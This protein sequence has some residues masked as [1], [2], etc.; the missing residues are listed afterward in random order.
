MRYPF[1]ATLGAITL[2][3]T[4]CGSERSVDFET[5]DGDPGEYTIDSETGESSFTIA[6]DEG[7]ISM[8]SGADVP[9]DLPNGIALMDGARVMSNTVVN[10]VDGM[11]TMITFESGSS[12]EEVVEYYR[13]QAENA[14]IEIQIETNMNGGR[15]IGGESESGLTMSV[16]ANPTEDGS[17]GQLIVGQSPQD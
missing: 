16:I 17:T 12:P 4:A 9:I 14:G 5:E 15:M 13:T 10:Q 7:E 1:A 6:T 8:R 3:V 11:G 2:S